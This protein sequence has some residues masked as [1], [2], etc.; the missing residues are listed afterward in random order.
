M[1]KI[2]VQMNAPTKPSTVFLGESLIKGVLPNDMP[3]MYAQ[4]SLQM[5]NE[6]GRKNQIMPWER[7]SEETRPSAPDR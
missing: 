6:A 3:Q 7:R 4:M 5:T 1:E 2:T